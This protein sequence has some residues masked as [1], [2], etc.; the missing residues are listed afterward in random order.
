VVGPFAVI[1]GVGKGSGVIVH[2]VEVTV[3]GSD[4]LSKI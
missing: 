2:P 1:V 4:K 3:T